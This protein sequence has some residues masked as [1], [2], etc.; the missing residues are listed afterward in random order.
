MSVVGFV[1]YLYIVG[2]VFGNQADRLFD[3]VTN[4]QVR[5]CKCDLEMRQM[6]AC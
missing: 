6:R 2:R 3:L 5:G 1:F 4:V